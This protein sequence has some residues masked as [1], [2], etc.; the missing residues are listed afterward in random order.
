[1]IEMRPPQRQH[2]LYFSRGP[3]RS[4][5]WLC[6][7]PAVR[8]DESSSQYPELDFRSLLHLA[9]RRLWMGR[10]LPG[11][12]LVEKRP[13]LVHRDAENPVFVRSGHSC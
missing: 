8:L 9:V 1:M 11:Y 4:R 6:G 5:R 12:E 7:A 2:P 3:T 13:E 10:Q